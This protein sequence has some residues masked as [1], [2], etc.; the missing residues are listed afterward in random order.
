MAS[1][2]G[3]LACLALDRPPF[4]AAYSHSSSILRPRTKYT[5]AEFLAAIMGASQSTPSDAAIQEKL[6]ERLQALHTKDDIQINEKEG[7]LCVDNASRTLDR[8]VLDTGRS[9]PANMNPRF[10]A[11]A[12]SAL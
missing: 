7:Y 5:L 9:V 3:P 10:D 6:L 11:E 12:L 1:A 8:R 4:T 2:P